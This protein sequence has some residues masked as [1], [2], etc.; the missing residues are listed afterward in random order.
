MKPPRYAKTRVG[1]D[2]IDT[3]ESLERSAHR[4]FEITVPSNVTADCQSLAALGLEA[5]DQSVQ[6]F[7]P[8]GRRDDSCPE[9]DILSSQ[10]RANT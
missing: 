1:V 9:P 7:H 3:A 8:T 10:S 5:L 4:P 6:P 2:M